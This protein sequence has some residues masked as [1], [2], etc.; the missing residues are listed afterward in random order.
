[1]A[2]KPGPLQGTNGQLM[3]M[4][5]HRYCLGR[6]S[7]IVGSCIEWLRCWWPQLEIKTRNVIV[8]DTLEAL[9]DHHAGGDCDERGWRQ[10]FFWAWEQMDEESRAWCR[11][12]LAHRNK[13]WPLDD[14]GCGD[15]GEVG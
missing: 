1:M 8:R 6:Q 14:R 10:F 7:Y 13:P 4:A 12:A 9:Q 5:A 3:A 15:D 2:D 11:S